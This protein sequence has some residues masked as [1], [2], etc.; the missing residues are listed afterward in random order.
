M[1]DHRGPV[2]SPNKPNDQKP[3]FINGHRRNLDYIGIG[4]KRLS[5]NEINPVLLP[6]QATFTL[7]EFECV[8]GI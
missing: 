3:C 5:L 7:V 8:Y 1:R 4:P 6:I 2:L